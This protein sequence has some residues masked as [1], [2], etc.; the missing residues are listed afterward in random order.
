MAVDQ[1]LGKIVK[2]AAQGKTAYEIAEELG[3]T[4]NA[5]RYRI[6]TL[7]VKTR[8]SIAASR[9]RTR[10]EERFAEVKQFTDGLI[11]NSDSP[12]RHPRTVITD[13]LLLP[14]D[15]ES[16]IQTHLE[17]LNVEAMT[18]EKTLRKLIR[19]IEDKIQVLSREKRSA[20]MLLEIAKQ[21]K[22]IDEFDTNDD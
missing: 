11:D 12:P 4:Y 8:Q 3:L 20:E 19:D 5:V 18:A 15:N 17:G 10:N 14:L 6:N 1:I 7:D 9:K 22:S 21:R 16:E 13:D 2:L